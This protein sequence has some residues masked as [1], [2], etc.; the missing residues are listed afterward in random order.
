MPYETGADE[1]KYQSEYARK[2]K[3]GGSTHPVW[4]RVIARASGPGPERKAVDKAVSKGKNVEAPNKPST[5]TRLQRVIENLT[6]TSKITKP[7]RSVE[8]KTRPK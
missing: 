7:L 5:G 4:N 2:R 3:K 8:K 6:G 1:L